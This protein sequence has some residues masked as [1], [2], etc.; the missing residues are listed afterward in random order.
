MGMKAK[1]IKTERKGRYLL[2][3]ETEHGWKPCLLGKLSKQNCDELFG[4]VDVEK[5]DRKIRG[6]MMINGT[7][8][9]TIDH[10]NTDKMISL[11]NKAM[12]LNKD[13]VFTL[14]VVHAAFGQ[15]WERSKAEKNGAEF[16]SERTRFLK[17][18]QQPTEIEVEIEMEDDKDTLVDNVE[19]FLKELGDKPKLDSSGCIILTKKI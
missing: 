8:S 5:L 14:E 4:V 17:Y 19:Q 10:P 3:E 15:G 2:L 7:S 16:Y 11:F 9:G 12:E 1:L 6:L 18:I 13:K